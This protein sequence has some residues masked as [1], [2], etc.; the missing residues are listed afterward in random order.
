MEREVLDLFKVMIVAHKSDETVIMPDYG[1]VLDFQ[2]DSKQTR[3]LKDYFKPLEMRTLFSREER[4]NADL[5]HLITKQILHY[6]EVYGLDTP[7]LFNLEVDNGIVVTMNYVRGVTVDEL[8]E[9]V[10]KLLY[11]NA[12]VK[13]A[14]TL[15]KIV[16][17]FRVD[18]DIN[19][20]ANNELRV[21]LFNP[22]KHVF[23]DG[24]DAVRWLVYQATGEYLLI[25]SPEVIQKCK[26]YSSLIDEEFWNE[27]DRVLS[28]VFNRHKAILLAFKRRHARHI[29]HVSRM[30]KKNHKPLHQSVAKTFVSRALSGEPQIEDALRKIGVRDKFKY[31]NL[32]AYKREGNE[33]DAFVV[34]NGKVHFEDGRKVWRPSDIQR[35]ENMVLES[36]QEDLAH[37]R[38]MNILLDERVH[39]GLPISRK[40]AVGQ[41]PYGT[42]VVTG[43]G[44]ISA[45]IYWENDWGAHDLDLST[46]D[47]RGVRTGWG[48]LSGYDQ[49]SPVTF[50]GDVTSAPKGAMEFMTSRKQDYGLFVNIFSGMLGCEMEVVVGSNNSKK[51]WI[52]DPIIRE[53]TTLQSRGMVCGFVKGTDFVVY[54]G[55]LGNDR[56]SGGSKAMIDRGMADFW[57]INDLLRKLDIEYRVYNMEDM[58]YDVNLRYEGFSYDKLEEVLL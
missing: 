8:S 50:S 6:I 23:N 58:D 31:L 48:I 32:L 12:P 55:R 47:T 17:R 22:Q 4:D 54:Q 15:K 13:D 27:H 35:V 21:A 57:T 1:L 28:E 38:N 18:F 26:E 41:L 49:N 29:N 40:Q 25:K 24:D 5:E 9:M 56:V 11:R 14:E 46:I 52:T 44:E 33:V 45:G 37:L 53:K 51:K 19:K 20:I 39:Y 43:E 2:P 36:L 16:E 34:R 30:S 42:R 7:G 3:V 10:R